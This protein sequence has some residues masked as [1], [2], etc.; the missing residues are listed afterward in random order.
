MEHEQSDTEA[1]RYYSQVAAAAMQRELT[2][3]RSRIRQLDTLV[4][5]LN[6]EAD[7]QAAT[8]EKLR[9]EV[10]QWRA[11]YVQACILTDIEE[12]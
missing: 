4:G 10:E 1:P 3:A 2:S 8:I 9:E 12:E 5:M 11:R 7:Q 6:R